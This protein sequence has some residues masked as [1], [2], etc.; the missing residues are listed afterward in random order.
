MNNII[1]HFYVT[2]KLLYAYVSEN[3]LF[4]YIYKGSE[5]I[6]YFFAANIIVS[7]MQWHRNKGYL[8]H[9]KMHLHAHIDTY[10]NSYR[11]I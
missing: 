9:D 10:I 7:I 11:S 3:K 4:T 5:R 1:L 8:L 2:F 6:C